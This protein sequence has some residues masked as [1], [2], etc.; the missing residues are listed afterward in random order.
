MKSTTLLCNIAIATVLFTG[1]STGTAPVRGKVV[2]SDG[3]PATDLKDS[4]VVFEGVGADGKGY[5][6]T[7]TI[8]EAGNFVLV[9]ERPGDGVVLGKNK[10]LIA[11]QAA[12]GDQAQ[13][14]I[15]D[16]KFEAF[17]TSGLEAE[18]TASG[19][20]DFTFT[21]ERAKADPKKPRK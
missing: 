7:G 15:I 4:Q 10:V 17:A 3:S 1:C 11:P 20:N 16:P 5:S 14:K 19:P 18:V 2:Y 12:A 9:T 21:V 8:D 6:A 13:P